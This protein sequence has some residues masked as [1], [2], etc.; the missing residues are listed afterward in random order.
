M[1]FRCYGFLLAVLAAG[2]IAMA[3]A[4]L[5]V[6]I[7]FYCVG[8][9]YDD[10]YCSSTAEP[11]IWVW[12]SSGIWGGAVV[13][14][15]GLYLLCAGTTPGHHMYSNLLILLSALVFAPAII[16]LTTIEIVRGYFAQWNFYRSY[17]SSD[18]WGTG[19]IYTHGTNPWRAKY[20]IPLI[21]DILAGLMFIVS[22]WL[23][24]TIWCCNGR[25]CFGQCCDQCCGGGGQV[26][27]AQQAPPPM[28]PRP[29]IMAPAPC[30]P[31]AQPAPPPCSPCAQPLP[32]ACSPCRMPVRY[33]SCVPCGG[34]QYNNF[35]P[36]NTG[37]EYSYFYSR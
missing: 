15:T 24:L 31:C 28:Q 17:G 16:V 8:Q 12:V 1:N 32:P 2:T 4:D 19:N 26:I 36:F 23:A 5:I 21:T 34:G 22:A 9:D 29:Q 10:T 25:D 20:T 27:Y 13:F 35:G 33:N 7:Q 18:E 37:N 6:T 14:F 3:V 30:S 11:Y